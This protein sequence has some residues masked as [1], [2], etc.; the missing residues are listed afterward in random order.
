MVC[1]TLPVPTGVLRIS[2][3]GY[4]GIIV[5]SN[6]ISL[7]KGGGD[8]NMIFGQM[9]RPMNLTS[10]YF[11]IIICNLLKINIFIVQLHTRTCIKLSPQRF[12]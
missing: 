9:F 5:Q 3:Q 1:E 2:P 8:L 6:F 11:I 12:T 10:H 4:I 7:W